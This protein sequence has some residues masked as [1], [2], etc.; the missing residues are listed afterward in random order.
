M[1]GWVFT[2]GKRAAVLGAI[3]RH[4][5]IGW[6]LEEADIKSATFYKA[7]NDDPAFERAVQDALLAAAAAMMEAEEQAALEGLGD[8][9]GRTLAD[10]HWLRARIQGKAD[11]Y[12]YGAGKGAAGDGVRDPGRHPASDRAR[13][14]EAERAV[15]AQLRL[16]ARRLARARG[17]EG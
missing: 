2:E 1:A 10:N 5:R 8:G 11:R 16:L 17:Q 13:R 7:R 4:G 15:E 9:T 14:D 12:R 3:R 6:A